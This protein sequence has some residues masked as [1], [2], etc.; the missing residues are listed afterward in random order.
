MK[1]TAEYNLN[2]NEVPAK[3]NVETGETTTLM[4]RPNNIPEGKR[5]FEPDAL[6][7]KDYTNS[8]KFL[9]RNLKPIEFKAAFTLALKAKANTNSLEPLSDSTTIPELMEVLGISKNVVKPLLKK[10]WSIGVYGK[11]E[12]S[13]VG[14]PYTKY[15]ILNPYLSFS[16]KLID[17]DI[18]ELFSKT[19]IA[20]AFRD[21]NYIIED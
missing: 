9:E 2:H 12:V 19:H 10:L 5:V 21:P 11:F 16:G 3:V 14:K 1:Y 13:E 20:K 18:A 6:F 8:W 7:R 15:W 4:K 17:S